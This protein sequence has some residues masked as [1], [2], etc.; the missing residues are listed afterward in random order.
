MLADATDPDRIGSS[1]TNLAS[2]ILPCLRAIEARMVVEV[3]ASHGDFTRELLTWAAEADTRVTAIEPSPAP[4]L[5][6]LAESDPR[7]ELVRETSREALPRLANAG[8]FIVDGD[9]NYY[10][11]SQDLR[12]IVDRAP[13]ERMPLVMLHDMGWPHGR[14]DAYY[15]PQAIPA[16][17]RQPLAHNAYLDPENPGVADGGFLVEWAAKREG[18]E[19]N[20]VLTAVEDLVGE[21]DDLRL[22][23]VP[24]FFGLGVMWHRDAPWAEAVGQIVEPWD[25]NPLL[26]R[27][28]ANRSLKMAE[29]ARAFQRLQ[30][31]DEQLRREHEQ[32]A[33]QEQLLR[34]MLAS[35][36][37]AW[38]ERLSRLRRGGQPSFSR[39]DVRRAIGEETD[40][41]V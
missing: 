25:R 5:V 31:S 16:E 8:A 23:V 20:G 34:R 19:R 3:G 30:W 39:D 26:E 41:P 4:E 38:G 36:A 10:T 32:R 27:L 29:W 12:L 13:G 15:D 17:D 37:F 40:D 7:L 18:G 9:H 33:R 24:A 2:V 21:G 22:V 35:R 6:S 14:R 28:E 11:V 1:L